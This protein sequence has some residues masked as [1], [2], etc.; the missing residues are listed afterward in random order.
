MRNVAMALV[1]LSVLGF[2]M[3]V[4]VILLTGPV[5]GIS[6]EGFSRGSGNLA[7]IAIALIVIFPSGEQ[8]TTG[9]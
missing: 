4:M 7:L 2:L 3:A 5:A 8:E 1:V 9:E 6:A